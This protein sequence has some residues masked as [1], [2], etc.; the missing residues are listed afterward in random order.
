MQD[1]KHDR[2]IGS[3]VSHL[4]SVLP[5]KG[6]LQL[7]NKVAGPDDKCDGNALGLALCS[8]Q[9]W[10]SLEP[11][12]DVGYAACPAS[13]VHL[14]A[15]HGAADS[16]SPLPLVYMHEILACWRLTNKLS[17]GCFRPL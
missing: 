12:C 13:W 7:A 3:A 4:H 17:E 15:M 2:S 8:M 11:G 6:K 16:A 5:H 1:L 14:C 9:A 10:R